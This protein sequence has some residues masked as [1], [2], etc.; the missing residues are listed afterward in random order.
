MFTPTEKV[1]NS[2]QEMQR[3]AGYRKN[4]LWS[5]LGKHLTYQLQETIEQVVAYNERNE[6]DFRDAS[7][8]IRVLLDAQK[9]SVSYSLDDD[10][11][12]IVDKLFTRL[13]DNETCAKKTQDKY[14]ALGVATYI[15]FDER[16]GKYIN[17]VAETATGTDGET[18]PKDKWLKSYKFQTPTFELIG[19]IDERENKPKI[20]TVTNSGVTMFLGTE[21]ELLT[22]AKHIAINRQAA[23]DIAAGATEVEMSFRGEAQNVDPEFAAKL[24][25]AI[26]DGIPEADSEMKTAVGNAIENCC[27]MAQLKNA[28]LGKARHGKHLSDVR[29]A[30]DGKSFNAFITLTKG[31]SVNFA[32]LGEV[33]DMGISMDMTDYIESCKMVCVAPPHID[34]K[35]VD[36]EVNHQFGTITATNNNIHTVNIHVNFTIGNLNRKAAPV[37]VPAVLNLVQHPFNNDVERVTN[38]GDGRF[39]IIVA[40]SPLDKRTLD[41]EEVLRGI[42]H[43]EGFNV[44]VSNINVTSILPKDA[45]IPDPE[46]DPG[47]NLEVTEPVRRTKWVMENNRE[48]T[49]QVHLNFTL[50]K[51]DS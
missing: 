46:K 28:V 22:Y 44:I 26:L 6:E 45:P 19:L 20:T 43:T 42:S 16:T 25:E 24:S 33:A 1:A 15:V 2:S 34:A 31:Q 41:L 8:D 49:V 4:N 5:D 14:A 48:Y 32:L 30:D 13:D 51:A 21:D 3:I 47:V 37:E 18:Y 17:R 10:Y 50:V 36:F 27:A 35:Q 12:E 9:A 38:F 11:S 7:G 39:G 40:L 29:L 23:I